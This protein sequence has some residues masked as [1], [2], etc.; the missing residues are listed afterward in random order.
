MISLSFGGFT[1]NLLSDFFIMSI[2]NADTNQK[3]PCTIMEL[4]DNE[5]YSIPHYP[6]DNNTFISD[7]II[8]MPLKVSVRVAVYDYQIKAFKIELKNTQQSTKGFI[9]NGINRSYSNMRLSESAHS[10]TSDTIGTS[11]YNL[12]FEECILI[13]SFNQ[14]FNNQSVKKNQYKNNVKSGAKLSNATK[15]ST[16][17]SLVDKFSKVK[18]VL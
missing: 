8:Q 2:Q 3:L 16:L 13:E 14:K 6:L 11:F 18:S 7:T 4:S 15:K 17:K 9:I 1:D 12:E 10:E 5:S